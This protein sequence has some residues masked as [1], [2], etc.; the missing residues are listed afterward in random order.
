[1]LTQQQDSLDLVREQVVVAFRQDWEVVLIALGLAV[2]IRLA[3]SI[4]R[5]L[6]SARLDR[7]G[8][9]ATGWDDL[10]LRLVQRTG[11]AFAAVV[12]LALLPQL[13][14][15]APGLI[16]AFRFW[17]RV[18]A[19]VQAALWGNA[20]ITFFIHRLLKRGGP[21][22]Q[23]TVTAATAL[24]FAARVLLFVVVLIVGLDAMGVRITTLVAGLGIG[25]IVVALAL[26]SVLTDLIGALSIVLNRPFL[27]GDFIQAGQHLGTVEYVGLRST[28]IRSLP[29]QEL[30]L[31]NT[32]L[33]QNAIVNL[34]RMGERRV[35]FSLVLAYDTPIAALEQVRDTVLEIVGATPAARFD[36][37]H[38]KT[39]G[40]WGYEYE[41]IYWILSSDY[42][43]YMDA[44]ERIN[45]EL[46]RRLEADGI[47]LG[48]PAGAALTAGTMAGGLDPASAF[49]R[50]R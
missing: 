40:A 30:H 46:L 50:E 7:P 29:G 21:E 26:Q 4:P 35:S 33:L 38:L 49:G 23:V 39:F 48:T 8:E 25:S 41:I 12:S 19:L 42:V 3:L 47:R 34:S 15:V 11:I 28:R 2:A 45:L 1:V 5:R 43:V 36:R 9:L 16:P 10:A 13:V 24:G 37:A 31:P 20:A 22:R 6:A 32:Y 27:V 44:R 17:G 14:S 18:L